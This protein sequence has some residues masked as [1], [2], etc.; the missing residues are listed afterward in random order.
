MTIDN[1][2]VTQGVTDNYAQCVSAGQTYIYHISII[3]LPPF[4]RTREAE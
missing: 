3:N 2:Q 1:T 4:T